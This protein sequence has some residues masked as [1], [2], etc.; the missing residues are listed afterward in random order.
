MA[1]VRKGISKLIKEVLNLT[2]ILVMNMDMS[3]FIFPSVLQSP[4]SAGIL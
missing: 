3:R 1:D 4:L 2:L